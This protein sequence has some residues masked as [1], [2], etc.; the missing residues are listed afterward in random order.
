MATNNEIRA[1]IAALMTANYT[2]ESIT[3]RTML[4]YRTGYIDELP[5]PI[6]MVTQRS[7]AQDDAYHALNTYSVIFLVRFRDHNDEETAEDHLTDMMEKTYNLMRLKTTQNGNRSY[8]KKVDQIG[9][10]TVSTVRYAGQYYK[11]GHMILRAS[12]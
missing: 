5:S 6:T 11:Q 7:I 4:T 9:Q 8:W 1:Q 3:N 12:I 2:A 10:A